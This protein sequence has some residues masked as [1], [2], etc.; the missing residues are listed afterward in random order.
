MSAFFLFS[1]AERSNVKEE[2]PD[3]SFGEVVSP[4]KWRSFQ[5]WAD[6]V[7]WFVFAV[8]FKCIEGV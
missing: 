3:A 8:F 1:Q 5:I 6:V 4:Q 7:F 2:F